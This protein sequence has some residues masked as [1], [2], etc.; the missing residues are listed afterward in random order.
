MID[1]GRGTL[2][3]SDATGVV[4]SESLKDHLY[5]NFEDLT[6]FYPVQSLRGVY[7]ASQLLADDSI[8]TL[9]SYNRGGD[10]QPISRPDGI[11]CADETKVN[12][13]YE[14]EFVL[15]F[16]YKNELQ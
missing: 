13:N 7:I 16:F 1:T 8:H 6:D 12:H 11:P 10:W 4:F 2:Y 9:I 3:I 14:F 5:P 15:F